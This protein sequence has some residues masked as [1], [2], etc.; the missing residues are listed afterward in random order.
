MLTNFYPIFD[1]DKHDDVH[2]TS[3]PFLKLYGP[4]LKATKEAVTQGCECHDSIINPFARLDYLF[5]A[6]CELG[7]KEI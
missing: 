4:A 6:S 3:I 1:V 2:K 5:R 7:S